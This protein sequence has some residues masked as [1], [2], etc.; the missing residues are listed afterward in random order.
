MP[1]RVGPE[2]SLD[3]LEELDYL[4]QLNLHE[5]FGVLFPEH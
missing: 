3:G 4:G 5:L 2:S 1:D